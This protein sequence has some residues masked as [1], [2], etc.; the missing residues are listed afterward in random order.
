MG[1]KRSVCALL[2]GAAVAACIVWAFPMCSQA[3]AGGDSSGQCKPD[4]N[5]ELGSA[6]K[7]ISAGK[8]GGAPME[9]EVSIDPRMDYDEVAV[10]WTVP[11]ELKGR[12]VPPSAGFGA[13]K[14]GEARSV[15]VKL[16]VADDKYHAIGL[17]VVGYVQQTD[18]V[19]RSCGAFLVEMNS[20]KKPVA[21]PAAPLP[22]QRD[23][24]GK[25]YNTLK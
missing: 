14:A 1:K 15:R 8:P 21:K 3:V 20:D 24:N 13:A 7:V 6:V 17:S 10:G 9:L 12:L 18:K 22:K 25:V 16:P 19:A 23:R 2:V 4:L 11:E 5:L